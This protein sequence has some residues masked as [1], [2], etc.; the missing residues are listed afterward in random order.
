LLWCGNAELHFWDVQRGREVH[1]LQ[2]KS[3]ARPTGD[4]GREAM[5][6]FSYSEV[7][8]HRLNEDAFRVQAHPLDENCSLCFVA[9]GQ[10]GR[11]GGGP[12]A[13]LACQVGLEMAIASRP[14]RLLLPITWSDILRR[15]D[16]AVTA[17]ATAGF[18]TIVGLCAYEGWVVGV[19]SGDSAALLVSGEKSLEL[20]ARQQKNPPVGSGGAVA[21]PF[22]AGLIEPWR[23]LAMTDGVWK[24]VG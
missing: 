3:S 22:A 6:W 1:T 14:E 20:T 19:S 2:L 8:G 12:A 11:A 4:E 13:V 9:D 15:A 21:V 18:T 5:K 24:Y 7:G 17:E 16:S 23:I 10:G